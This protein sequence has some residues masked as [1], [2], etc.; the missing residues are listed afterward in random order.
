MTGFLPRY[1][2]LTTSAIINGIPPTYA[3]WLLGMMNGLS[4]LGRV[5]IGYF[6]DRFGKIQAL[7][8]SFILCGVGHFV[9]WL[10]GVTVAVD[11]NGVP[12][13]LFTLFVVYIGIFGS[14]FISLFAVVVS[15]LFG[16][17]ALA[18]KTGLLNTTIGVSVLAGPSA[19]Y[20]IIESGISKS[21]TIGVLGKDILDLMSSETFADYTQQFLASGLF[22][23]VGGLVLLVAGTA[24]Q[25]QEREHTRPREAG[26][27]SP[28]SEREFDG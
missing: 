27:Q 1:F 18:S 21:W 26:E 19:V 11:D 5:G 9:F 7:T 23:F 24:M 25:K 6:A 14:G 28:R 8:A 22:L 16:S 2:L 3:S 12:T 17:E 4:I 10:P 13:A 15:H 20:A